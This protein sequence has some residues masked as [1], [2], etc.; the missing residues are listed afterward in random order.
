MIPGPQVVKTN[1][2]P[3]ETLSPAAKQA[4][5]ALHGLIANAEDP[6]VW[7]AQKMT[8]LEVIALQLR[9]A[10]KFN[11]G[12]ASLEEI[13]GALLCGAAW[14]AHHHNAVFT[15]TDDPHRKPS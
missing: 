6:A 7:T 15:S 8:V 1:I 10:G 9:T 5:I 12:E 14:I 3:S 11:D 4:T 2:R 13:M